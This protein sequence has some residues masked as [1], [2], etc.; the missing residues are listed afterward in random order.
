[1]SSSTCGSTLKRAAFALSVIASLLA[2]G[3]AHAWNS[4]L[5]ARE[6]AGVYDMQ[7]GSIVRINHSKD[8]SSSAASAAE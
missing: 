8:S 7:D 5:L 2:S 4:R 6:V 3:A 1:M